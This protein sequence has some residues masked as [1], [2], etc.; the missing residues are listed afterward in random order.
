MA[1]GA[2]VPPGGRGGGGSGGGGRSLADLAGETSSAGKPARMQRGGPVGGF[3]EDDKPKYDTL[4]PLSASP[5]PFPFRSFLS[6][7]LS[8]SL[9][10]T[11]CSLS[12]TGCDWAHAAA[13]ALHC[14]AMT[15]HVGVGH[16]V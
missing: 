9:L 1:G 14:I 12:A 5:F 10:N 16:F 7:S 11:P 8:L 6:L 13:A 4:P 3:V 15:H 2:Y